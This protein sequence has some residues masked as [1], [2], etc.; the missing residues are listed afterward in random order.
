M[1]LDPI[2]NPHDPR[3]DDFRNLTDAQARDQ[4]DSFIVEGRLNVRTLLTASAYRPRSLLLTAAAAESLRDLLDPLAG[5]GPPVY[6]APPAI[7]NRVAGFDVHRG[8]LAAA[9]RGHPHSLGD[10]LRAVGTGPAVILALEDINNHDNIGGI[11]RNAA[12]FAAGGA[13]L[14]QGSV[15]PLYRKSIRVSM[16]GVLRVPFA[17][18]PKKPPLNESSSEVADAWPRSLH[19]L[20]VAGFT[21][22]ALTPRAGA[23]DLHDFARA[24]PLPSRFALL[25]GAEGPGLTERSLAAAD[26]LVRIALSPGVDSLNVASAAAIALH[27][28]TSSRPG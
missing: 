28:L 26:A 18:L 13:L 23:I 8:C 16:G 25:L 14:S 3:L 9:E 1:R 27:A 2:D 10:L 20:R 17:R 12:A 7:V 4:R 21:I 15:D 19:A 22:I 5:E 24:R 6:L 11:F